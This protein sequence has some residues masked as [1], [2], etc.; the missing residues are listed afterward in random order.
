LQKP[1]IRFSKHLLGLANLAVKQTYR[2]HCD[3]SDHGD[4]YFYER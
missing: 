1:N 2:K 4:L 3:K